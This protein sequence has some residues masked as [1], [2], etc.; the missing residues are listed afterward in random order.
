MLRSRKITRMLVA[1]AVLASASAF[2][3][4]PLSAQSGDPG[5]EV[6]P[7]AG[8]ISAS[9]VDNGD[10]TMTLTYSNVDLEA[11]EFVVV[12][13]FAA[14]STCPAD[15]DTAANDPTQPFV[16]TN[17]ND[18]PLPPSPVVI[19]PGT[20]AYKLEFPSFVSAT[21]TPAD[22]EVCLYFPS[23]ESGIASLQ[24]SLAVSLQEP[25]PTTTT[26]VAP[27]TTT[28]APPAP[29]PVTPAFTG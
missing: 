12:F 29:K 24:Q 10:G 11:G 14:G 27:T 1:V 15:A 18:L 6:G 7:A 28:T 13:L 9:V 17:S 22:Y 3:S 21:I 5:G 26:T 23:D 16:L 2:A 20:P 19:G 8:D 25:A 4:A